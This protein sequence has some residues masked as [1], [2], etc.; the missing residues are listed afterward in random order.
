M[1]LFHKLTI[2][3]SALNIASILFVVG[4]LFLLTAAP[5]PAGAQTSCRS[6]AGGYCVEMAQICKGGKCPGVEFLPGQI[7]GIEDLLVILYTFGLGIT[8]LSA[9]VMITF[10]G[11]LYLSAG[12]N[13]TLITEAR[14]HITNALVGLALALL[15]W[16]ILKTINPDL[17][18]GWAINLPKL[19]IKQG[20]GGP[21][22]QQ[23]YRCYTDGIG[24]FGKKCFGPEF[25]EPACGGFPACGG[26]GN[27]CKPIQ[28][29]P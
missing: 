7:N 23:K 22:V 19:E 9:F 11:V 8:A 17:I 4:I 14:K 2:I 6:A 21:P 27:I 5:A 15:S 24:G 25:D 29:C 10:G 13:Q 3:V 16:L 28:E 12:D 26:G 18:A 1:R 20:P